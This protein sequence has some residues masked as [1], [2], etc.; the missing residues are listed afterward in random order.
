[1][2]RHNSSVSLRFITLFHDRTLFSSFSYVSVEK[3]VFIIIL[4]G[5]SRSPLGT[6]ATNWPI[7][8]VPHGR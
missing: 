7:V 8:P 4:S 5:V 1:M 2:I 3:Y 6:A